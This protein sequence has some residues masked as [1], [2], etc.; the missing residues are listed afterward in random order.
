VTVQARL[1]LIAKPAVA[2]RVLLSPEI[3]KGLRLLFELAPPEPAPL[4]VVTPPAAVVV[5]VVRPGCSPTMRRH[6]SERRRRP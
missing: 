4:P 3:Q 1:E 5:Y 2:A 6:V